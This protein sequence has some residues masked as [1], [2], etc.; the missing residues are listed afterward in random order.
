LRP[1]I[2]SDEAV[3]KAETQLENAEAQATDLGIGRARYEHA[4]ALLVGQPASTFSIPIEPP[5]AYPPAI[6]LVFRRNCL[7]GVR[8]FIAAAERLVAQA[9]AQ[10][11]IAKVT[12]SPAVILSAS[13]GFESSSIVDWFTWPSRFGSVGPS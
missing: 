3:A 10:I 1:G 2:D 7:S 5:K 4:I 8:I 11:G 6:S 9:N 13:A 12:Y